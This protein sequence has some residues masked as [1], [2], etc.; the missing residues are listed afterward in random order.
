MESGIDVS[1]GPE[2]N[3]AGSEVRHQVS[4]V[5]V[6]VLSRESPVLSATGVSEVGRGLSRS[7]VNGGGSECDEGHR[8]SCLTWKSV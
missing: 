2:C 5:P 7:G 3:S 6:H 1:R 4:G 8:M